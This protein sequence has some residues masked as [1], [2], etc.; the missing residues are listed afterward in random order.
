MDLSHEYFGKK[1]NQQLIAI[2]DI[3]EPSDT[4]K[5][6]AEFYKDMNT[7]ALRGIYLKCHSDEKL[8]LHKA[9][10]KGHLGDAVA[11]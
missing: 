7:L 8:M 5:T 11:M 2:F 4:G 10:L 3:L 6:L 1:I 9:F